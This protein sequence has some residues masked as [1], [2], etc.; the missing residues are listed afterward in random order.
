MVG[1][2]YILLSACPLYSIHMHLIELKL[3]KSAALIY[4]GCVF[5]LILAG[6]VLEALLLCVHVRGNWQPAVGNWFKK[7]IKI[8]ILMDYPVIAGF[9]YLPSDFQ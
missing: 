8:K 9:C 2:C 7:I 6:T 4:E 1:E 5:S 3:Q